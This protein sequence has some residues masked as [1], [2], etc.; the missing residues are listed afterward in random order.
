MTVQNM[1]AIG[2]AFQA[3]KKRGLI[4]C[5]REELLLASAEHVFFVIAIN[6]NFTIKN[7]Y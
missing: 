2:P 7:N 4:I 5:S 6:L 1:T 3:V